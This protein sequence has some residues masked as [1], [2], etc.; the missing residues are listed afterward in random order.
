[1]EI[2]F[3]SL[4]EV[5]AI[6]KEQIRRFG[7]SLG[8]RDLGL[9]EAAIHMPQ[10]TFSGRFLHE[11]L[12]GMAAAYLFHLVA[13]HP[14][15][16]GNKRVGAASADVFLGMNGWQLSAEPDTY[17]SFVLDTAARKMEKKDA[18]EFFRRH[19]VRLPE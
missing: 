2:T 9:L 13:N 19:A 3:L 11:D 18:L 7:G 6:H 12:Q 16:D 17:A 4:A 10:A 5:L 8:L 15:I 1:M 14:F